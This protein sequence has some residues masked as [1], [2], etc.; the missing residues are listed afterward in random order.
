MS[1]N[2]Q[3]TP[4]IS[5]FDGMVTIP[6]AVTLIRLLCLP[7]FLWV[8]FGLNNQHAAAWLLGSIGATDWVDGYLA[9]RL[10]QTSEFGKIFD[11]TVDR[12]LF[13]VGVIALIID[14][15]VPLW[16]AVIV[17]GRELFVAA[18]ML[19][20]TFVFNMER[21]DVTWWGK[22]ATF[23]LMLTFPGFLMGESGMPIAGAF[24]ITSWIL[25]VPG[26]I[27]SVYTALAYIPL[28]LNGVRA[29]KPKT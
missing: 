3:Q 12:L 2:D 5:M 28:V 20:A 13:F 9:R 1:N 24:T 26:I 27:L 11:P 21:F 16:F 7:I 15:S 29:N 22:T 25:G 4:A 10:N 23:L 8:L 18:M 17:L 6:N 14:G 19:V